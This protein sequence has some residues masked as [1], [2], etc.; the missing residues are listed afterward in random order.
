[1]NRTIPILIA[2]L[3]KIDESPIHAI[4]LMSIITLIM[5]IFITIIGLVYEMGDVFL[6]TTLPFTILLSF[7]VWMIIITIHTNL[8]LVLDEYMT[9]EETAMMLYL[10]RVQVHATKKY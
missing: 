6:P 9:R 8:P 1:M 4:I 2:T 5:H 10:C 7:I 3:K